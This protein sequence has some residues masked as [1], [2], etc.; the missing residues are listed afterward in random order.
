MSVLFC[1]NEN[2]FNESMEELISNFPLY[3]KLNKTFQYLF[4][5]IEILFQYAFSSFV[6]SVFQIPLQI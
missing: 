2:A 5:C 3:A 1:F 4:F 6:C